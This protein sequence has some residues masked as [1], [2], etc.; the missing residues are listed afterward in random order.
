MEIKNQP[1]FSLVTDDHVCVGLSSINSSVGLRQV[2]VPVCKA[3]PQ[4]V[5]TEHTVFSGLYVAPE[6]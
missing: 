5:T 3:P 1:E 6:C 4:T 2:I